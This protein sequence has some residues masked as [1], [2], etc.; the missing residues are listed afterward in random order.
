MLCDDLEG[1]VKVGWEGG[2]KGKGYICAYD[3]LV[4]LYCTD[5]HNFV[6]Q[7]SSN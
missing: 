2:S 5:P 1:D 3:R 4:K 6:K 7:L